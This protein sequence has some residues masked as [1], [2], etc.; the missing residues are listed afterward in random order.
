M[1]ITV[2]LYGND[3][4]FKGIMIIIEEIV[5]ESKA[6]TFVCTIMNKKYCTPSVAYY[7]LQHPIQT[8]LL[9]YC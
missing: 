5:V 7:F 9:W 6:I 3:D 1:E 4:Y 2:T 8:L